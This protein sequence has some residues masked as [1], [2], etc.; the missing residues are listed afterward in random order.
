MVVLVRIVVFIIVA[1]P[2][3]GFLGLLNT[4]HFVTGLLA[5]MFGQLFSDVAGDEYLNN[6]KQK[7]TND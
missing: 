1:A 4:N 2:V 3:A 7:S 6:Q 5:G